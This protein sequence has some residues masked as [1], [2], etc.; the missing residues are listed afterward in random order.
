MLR[1]SPF[2][3]FQYVNSTGT[4]LSNSSWTPMGSTSTIG[5]TYALTN[6]F[7]RQ[8]CSANW[9]TT[10]LADGAHCG[11][12]STITIGIQVSRAF[13]FGLSAVLGIS[14]SAYNANNCQNFFG[15]WNL[16]TQIGLNQSTQLSVQRN[17]ICFGSNTTDTNVC[18]YTAGASSTVKQVDLGSSFPAN[19]PSGALS[20]DWFKFTLYWDTTKF[21]YKAVNTTTNVTVSGTFTALV[22]DIPAV[23]IVLYPQCARIMGTPQ[24][25][26][27]A[28]LQ[29][30]RFGVYY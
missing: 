6:N 21:F 26:G 30:Q 9:T 22:A 16:S 11:Y 12:A 28:R 23:S 7:T 5:S 13:N 3:G 10:A 19:R 1:D 29:V 20:T 27:Q 8:L 14:D 25:N 15:V 17:M 18:I 4:S 2:M 24:S